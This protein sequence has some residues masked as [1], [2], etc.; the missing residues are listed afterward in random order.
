MKPTVLGARKSTFTGK[1]RASYD[2]P[3][4]SSEPRGVAGGDSSDVEVLE[5]LLW[6]Q[7]DYCNTSPA[8]AL[9][10]SVGP[11]G[12]AGHRPVT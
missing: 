5:F 6:V 1:Y 4:C 10:L 7:F 12:E 11:T 3:S 8:D 9:R 2:A